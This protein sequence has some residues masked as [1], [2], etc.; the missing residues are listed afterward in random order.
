MV[1]V[2]IF[3]NIKFLFTSIIDYQGR[4]FHPTL[5]TLIWR[6]VWNTVGRKNTRLLRLKERAKKIHRLYSERQ[7]QSPIIAHGSN[8]SSFY[9]SFIMV[10]S[11]CIIN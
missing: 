1:F 11:Q 3:M 9:D 10:H 2:L 6:D 8:Y 5:G 7:V 4:G